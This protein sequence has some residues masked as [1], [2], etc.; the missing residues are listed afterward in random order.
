MSESITLLFIYRS[1]RLHLCFFSVFLCFILLCSYFLFIYS[2]IFTF[3]VFFP[4][5]LVCLLIAYFYLLSF[6]FISFSMVHFFLS[7][8]PLHP[9]PFLSS[10]LRSSVSFLS[11][12][13]FYSLTL[14]IISLSQ[15]KDGSWSIFVRFFSLSGEKKSPSGF[16][17]MGFLRGKGCCLSTKPRATSY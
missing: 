14:Y 8:F 12:S 6:F 16:I 17:L 4:S 5:V 15:R 13:F 11:S 7:C 9:P 10:F 1:F 3:H 2:F